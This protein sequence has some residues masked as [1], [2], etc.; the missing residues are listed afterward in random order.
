[1]SCGDFEKEEDFP[2][3]CDSCHEDHDEYGYWL[4]TYNDEDNYCCK[5]AAW[6]DKRS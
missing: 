6:L 1:M 2:G 5:V 3:H 4:C